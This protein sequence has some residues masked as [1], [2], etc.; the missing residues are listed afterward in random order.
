MTN[1]TSVENVHFRRDWLTPEEIGYRACAS[2]VSD[3]AAV[4]AAPLGLVLALTV[5]ESWREQI[6]AIADGIGAAA[7][8]ADITIL[9][10]D[11]SSGSELSIGVTALGTVDGA[12]TRA[13]ARPGDTLWVTGRLGGPRL[14]LRALQRGAVPAADH[15]ARFAHPAPRLRE[16]RWL[17]THGATAAI[18]IS[19][20]VAADA[21]HIAAASRMRLR[22]DIDR[23]P[24]ISGAST[25]DAAQ[26][27]EEYELLVSAPESMDA[28]AFV[29]EFGVP[30][31]PVGSVSVPG[32][33]GP[34]VD[35]VSA[36]EAVPLPRGH[37]HFA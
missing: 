23:L 37:D 27:G 9:G 32:N 29:R 6:M 28:A 30:L 5:P 15:R 18:D 16:A 1:D 19:D 26:G 35:G 31:T 33:A 17:A 4:A 13:G 11:L 10:G 7:I 14:A 25:S 34:G 24:C 3:L 12:L 20:G 8:D 2:A 22:L 21:A 36:G